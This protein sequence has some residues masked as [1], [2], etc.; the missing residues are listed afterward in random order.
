MT[1]FPKLFG[2]DQHA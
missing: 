1:K 2:T